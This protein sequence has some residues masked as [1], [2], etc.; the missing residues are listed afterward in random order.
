MKLGVC[1][2]V[3]NIEKAAA[4]GYDYIEIGVGS[5]AQLSD[6]D[7]QEVKKKAAE[8]P[9]GIL[10]ANVMLPGPFHVT[11]GDAD[12]QEIET[13][14]KKAFPRLAAIGIKNVVFGSG[15]ARRVPEGFPA[16]EAWK[17]ME[18][19]SRMIA[20]IAAENGI[21]IALEP[22]NRKETNIINSVAEGGK[23]VESVEHPAFMLL[24]DYYHVGVENEGL[25]GVAA[26]GKYLRHV[27]IA[28]PIERSV[29]QENDGGN[30]EAFF[31]ALK[32]VG[33]QG[34]VSVEARVNDFDEELPKAAKYLKSLMND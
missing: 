1:T 19:A 30:Y 10:A 7:F 6:E 4:F 8:A 29:P 24:A 12:H 33:Y 9:I 11:G 32:A 3:E 21:T 25:D 34:G 13:F 2:S 14:L 18:K 17:Q 28:H 16:E 27:H 15:G 5:V 22:L 23:L 31:A 26:Y 20:G